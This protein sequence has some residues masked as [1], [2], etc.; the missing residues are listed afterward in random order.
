VGN[1]DNTPMINVSGLAGAGPVWH[2]FMERAH[3]GLSVRDF[4][5]P[6]AIV[7]LEICADSGTL[8]S[9]VCPQRKKE[10]FFKDQP[11]LGPEYD[12]HQLIAIDRNSGLRANEFCRA[13]VEEKYF[14]V[15]PGEDGRTWAISQG[16]EQPPDQYC[17]STNIFAG[18]TSPLDGASVRGTITFEGSATAANFAGYQIEVGKGTNPPGYTVVVGPV[19]Q[20][21]EQGILGTLDT[22]QVENG[23]YT[24]RL[25]VFD[26]SG[27]AFDSKV[28]VLVDNL[29]TPTPAPTDTPTETVVPPS[30]TPTLIPATATETVV[31]PSD[32]PPPAATDTPTLTPTLAL[33]TDTPTI[34]PTLELP[35]NTPTITSTLNVQGTTEPVRG[36]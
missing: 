21:V 10:I 29:N 25:V 17:P 3:E 19:N 4:T 36:Q 1:A 5:R 23:P 27:G 22:T 30:D 13:N 35:A 14:R 24:L 12:I 28:R 9:Q 18:I 20:I 7:E 31:P 34:A 6:P 26:Q 33:P 16:I 11:P 8:P 32:T 15:Y 2:N